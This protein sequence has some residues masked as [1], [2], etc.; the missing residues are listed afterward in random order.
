MPRQ[1]FLLVN[2]A[3]YGAP[4]VPTSAVDE[5][6]EGLVMKDVGSRPAAHPDF[7]HKF[8]HPSSQKKWWKGHI[9]RGNKDLGTSPAPHPDIGQDFSHPSPQKEAAKRAHLAL[10]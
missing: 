10:T 2:Q 8:S 3:V 4:Q 1:F 6:L 5:A 9:Q 7:G